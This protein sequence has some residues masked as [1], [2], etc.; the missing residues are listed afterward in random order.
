LSE[1]VPSYHRDAALAAGVLA[2]LVGLLW[3]TDATEALWQPAPAAVGVLG[4]LVVELV[5][6]RSPSLAALWERR[7]VQL[8]GVVAVV[9][10][11]AWAY[12]TLGP[13]AVAILCW[14]LSTYFVLLG[15]VLVF[16]RNPLA[17]GD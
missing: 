9:G 15:A 11:G 1:T 2:A 16:D 6:L 4:A 14:G 10:G 3:A 17:T 5:F 12:Q 13:S 7:V 8:G